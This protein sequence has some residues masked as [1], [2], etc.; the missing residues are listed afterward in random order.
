M[1]IVYV[2]GQGLQRKDFPS[3]QG[4]SANVPRIR[5]RGTGRKRT[6]IEKLDVPPSCSCLL[7]TNL[8]DAFIAGTIN[9]TALPFCA[10]F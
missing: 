2:V 9:K 3:Y 5:T 7:V 1:Y 8:G 10:S 6:Q 4:V